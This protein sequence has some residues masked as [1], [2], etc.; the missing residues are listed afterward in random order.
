MKELENKVLHGDNLDIL[1]NIASNTIDMIYL[2]PPFFSQR[3]HKLINNGGLEYSF[4]DTWESIDQYISFLKVRINECYRILQSNGILFFHCDKHA[5]HY[6][7]VMLDNIFGYNNFINEIIW[8]Y[9]RWANA[10]KGL[11]NNHQNIFMYGK[12][13]NY[14]FNVKYQ[15]Y[16]PTTNIDQILLNRTRNEINKS[17]YSEIIV[18]EKKGVA[19]GDVWEIPFLN[20]KAKERVNYPT[21]K[22]IELLEQLIEISTNENDIILDPFCGSG[23]TLVA[24]KLLNRKYI[25]IDQS[26]D[27]VILAEQRLKNPI[28][29]LSILLKKGKQ[30]YVQKKDKLEILQ[31]IQAKP[32]Y[33][34]K[35]V[36][37]LINTP[38]GLVAVK[39]QDKNESLLMAVEKLQSF[40]ENKKL[41]HKMIIYNNEN[42]LF[43]S[44][45]ETKST[46]LIKIDDV[47]QVMVHIVKF[48][49]K[50][51]V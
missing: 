13:K 32:V 36:D 38:Y 2:D 4:N 7:K 40:I 33:R 24:S 23:S 11:Q 49:E 45:D 18:H 44:E 50:V 29:T 10:K 12:T 5:S 20:P 21:Q 8:S 34:N 16:S 15:E 37:G 39:I 14:T 42:S 41:L 35:S 31:K 28:K 9:K 51:Y 25:G 46:I 26:I 43:S 30:A 19:L 6:I 22:P 1:K 27:A 17:I 3:K 47:D 48:M